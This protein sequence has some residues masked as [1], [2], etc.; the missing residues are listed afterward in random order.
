MNITIVGS[1]RMALGIVQ[2]FLRT[3]IYNMNVIVRNEESKIR[4]IENLKFDLLNKAKIDELIVANLLEKVFVTT[5]FESCSNSILII[6]SIIEDMAEKLKVFKKIEKF[7]S[8]K[9]IIATNTSSLSIKVMEKEIKNKHLFLGLHFFNP[10][11]VMKLVEIIK[12]TE[13]S[14]DTV[15]KCKELLDSID[16][17]YAVVKDSPGFIVNRVLI[18]IINE[19]SLMLQDN[20][21]TKEEIDLALTLGANFPMGPLLLGD[22]IGLDV[23]YAILEN[24]YLS[25]GNEKYKPS[26]LIKEKVIKGEL[27]KKSKI[28]FYN[29]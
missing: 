23:I 27:G 13:T 18:P 20:I 3:N 17:N 22:I 6:E 12:G 24:L 2:V 11:P 26:N 16:K 4:F 29:Y 8:D 14:V 9:A 19:A 28:G 10:V 7:A 1:G 21:S 25:S 15:I 5:D